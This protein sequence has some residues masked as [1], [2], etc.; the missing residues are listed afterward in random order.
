MLLF[1][2]YLSACGVISQNSVQDMTTFTP[3]TSGLLTVTAI[4]PLTPTSTITPQPTVTPTPTITSTTFVEISPIDGFPLLAAYKQLKEG[5][6][7]TVRRDAIIDFSGD[8]SLLAYDYTGRVTDILNTN[9]GDLEYHFVKPLSDRSG[10]H[11]QAFSPDGKIFAEGGHGQILFIWDIQTGELLHQISSRY[12]F[13]GNADIYSIAFSKEGKYILVASPFDYGGV[14]VLDLETMQLVAKKNISAQD[15]EISAD[16]QQIIIG[17]FT[18]GTLLVEGLSA[19]VLVF[20]DYELSSNQ[21]YFSGAGAL[22]VAISNDKRFI[23]AATG[24]DIW[25]W[26]NDLDKEIYTINDYVEWPLKV[27]ISLEG[28]LAILTTLGEIAIWNLESREIVAGMN[29]PDVLDMLFSPDGKTLA[30]IDKK[31]NIVLWQ[32]P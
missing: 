28:N 16:G 14:A 17:G 3:T 2:C 9:T 4:I 19:P 24:K 29:Y 15:I 30:T 32:V 21:E 11:A 27:D 20:D 22:S 13:Y 23:A 31:E 8:G 12:L 7:A 6:D 10:T 26:D 5:Y 25:V 18:G 1:V